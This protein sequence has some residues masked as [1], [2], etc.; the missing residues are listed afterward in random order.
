MLK[1]DLTIPLST[2]V[3]NIS[4]ELPP[5]INALFG[6]SGC[7]KTSLL[8]SIAGIG[9][10]QGR[11]Q[12]A[13]EIWQDQ[14]PDKW[15]KPQARGVAMVFQDSALF[16]HLDVC[17][18]LDYAITR[19]QR[20]ENRNRSTLLERDEVISAVGITDLLKRNPQ[21]LSGGESQRVALARAL[22]SRP[23]LLLLDEAFSALD[24]ASR[25]QLNRYVKS[26]CG[27]YEI[28][29]L[30]VS[31]AIEDIVQMADTVVGI[32]DGKSYGQ[33]TTATFFANTWNNASE[34]A[35]MEIEPG[36]VIDTTFIAVDSEYHI[37]ELVCE[38]QKLAV[39]E[40]MQN[41]NLVRENTSQNPSQQHVVRLFIRAKD[42]SLALQAPSNI[43]IQNS[44]EG[45]VANMTALA[46]GPY[47]HVEVAIGTQQLLARITR[48]AADEL[49]LK[50]GQRIFALIKSVSIDAQ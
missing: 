39:P 12:F 16:T 38:G 43:S 42:V 20:A 23:R 30:I 29:A 3:L 18:N 4:T 25:R 32:R 50:K 2:F 31:H 11:I 28:N 9:K 24:S 6:P 26:I 40:L 35:Q 44:L 36:A 47:C 19:S 5:G 7:G 45:T 13:E 48:K 22:L 37:T 15:L 17:G 21:T 49:Q 14:N 27:E 1:I 33:A 41:S 8:K 10:G 46:T 34:A